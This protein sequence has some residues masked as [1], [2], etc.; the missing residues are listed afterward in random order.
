MNY[1]EK[2]H[3]TI[4]STKRAEFAVMV[5]DLLSQLPQNEV[6]M[7]LAFFGTPG[8]NE[9]YVARRVL[10]REKIRRYYGDCEPALSYV[11]QPPL[12]APLLMEVH[13]Y[14]PD[15][16]D[17]I[18][19]RHYQGVPYVL[20]ENASGLLMVMPFSRSKSMLSRTWA[21]ISRWLSVLVFSNRRS[22]SVDFPWSIWAM[23][24]KLR[25]FF[26]VE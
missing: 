7:R 13:S 16:Q 11:S 24:Q 1:C 9:E 3:Y 23:M 18:T 12:N 8:T 2:I 25:M 14:V 17:R 15:A 4:L 6:I 26:I 19:F 21:C 10:L 20:L 5:D 22:A